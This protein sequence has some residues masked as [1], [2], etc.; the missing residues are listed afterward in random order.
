MILSSVR[1]VIEH[2]NHVCP[3]IHDSSVSSDLSSSTITTAQSASTQ[4]ATSSSTSVVELPS[5]TPTKEEEDR[6]IREKIE[7]DLKTWE[8]KFAKAADKGTDDLEERVQEITQRQIEKQVHGVG[9][10]MVV[11][12]EEVAAS[13]IGKL[14]KTI[15][16]VVKSLPEEPSDEDEK[17]A[18]DEVAKAVRSAGLAIRTKA[19]ALREWRQKCDAETHSLVTAASD[20]TLEVIDSIRDLGLQE[21]GMRW[22]WMEGVTYEDWEKYNEVKKD[23]WR[24]EIEAVATTHQGLADAKAAAEEVESQGMTAAGNA[25]Q[26]LARLKDVGVWKIRAK[27]DTDDFS[28]KALPP[29]AAAAGQ[30]VMDK[31]SSAKD[32]IVG[33]S[34]GTA[35]SI[36]SQASEGAAKAASTVSSGVVGE[37][38]PMYESVASVASAKVGEASQQASEAV[39]GSTAAHEKARSS[40]NSHIKQASEAVADKAS[41]VAS[42]ASKKADQIST[43]VSSAVIGSSTPGYE[44]VASAASKSIKSAA[45][46]VSKAIPS[47]S[48]PV[49]ESASSIASSAAS[50]ASSVASQASAK[51]YGGAMAQ[52]VGERVPILDDPI[53]EDDD[54]TYSAKLQG[55]VNQAGDKYADA[56]RAVSEAFAPATKTQGAAG[57]ITS[58]ASE[59]YSS[60]LAAASSILYGAPQGT[61]ESISSVASGIYAEAVAA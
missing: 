61:G 51:V 45:S 40:A 2:A 20:S 24:E 59:Q 26:E 3:S 10:A 15:R 44:S 55:I 56:T 32:S 28:T 8:E 54:A 58:L 25:G 22:A 29:R 52:K 47:S 34:Q 50:S 36:I 46:Q 43:D 57:S 31:L 5:S 14:K 18:E 13:E 21:L 1:A 33:T 60:A 9:A 48:T 11:Q 37:E 16:K 17:T 53:N 12:I 35:D 4:D 23:D 19:L 41:S 38:P 7:N 30:K 42:A 39:M 27:D 6:K 49:Q